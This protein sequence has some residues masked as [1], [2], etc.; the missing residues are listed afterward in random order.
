MQEKKKYGKQGG[1]SAPMVYYKNEHSKKQL[2][3]FQCEVWPIDVI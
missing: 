1:K 3:I 2:N